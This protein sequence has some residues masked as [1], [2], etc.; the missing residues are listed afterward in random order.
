MAIADRPLQEQSDAEAIMKLVAEG[1]RVTDPELIRRVQQRADKVR[2][3]ILE[4]HGVVEW[5]VD[6]IRQSRDE[7]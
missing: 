7:R 4:K 5:A 1:K 6:L 2:R 3:E